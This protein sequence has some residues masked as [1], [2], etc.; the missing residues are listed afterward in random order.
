MT[1]TRTPTPGSDA[2]GERV[3]GKSASDDDPD[4][5]A[6][7]EPETHARRDSYWA[8]LS[9]E[10]ALP[11]QAA[12][13]ETGAW[14]EGLHDRGGHGADEH[15]AVGSGG[16]SAGED[17]AA[18]GG[19]GVGVVS[20]AGE[21]L[22][23]QLRH[24]REVL[25]GVP[26]RLPMV[27]SP[28]LARL[29]AEAT[30][31][32]AVAESARAAL[33]LDAHARGVIASSDNPR[34]DR[35]IEQACRDAGVP[36]T[37]K[38]AFTLKDIAETCEGHDA[39]ALREAVTTGRIGLDSAAMTARFYRRIRAKVTLNNWEPVLADLI[40]AV[41][42]GAT[43]KD[44][45]NAADTIIDQYGEEGAL[46]EG[47]EAA[48]LKRNVSAF[49][50]GRDGMLT[51]TVR[52][53]P[54]SEAIL[55]A[56]LTA[57]SIPLPGPDGERDQRSV[58]QRRADAL[59]ALA[60]K[61]TDA[62]PT[63]PG[64]GSKARVLITIGADTL[65]SGLH[66]AGIDPTTGHHYTCTRTRQAG[67]STGTSGAAFGTHAATAHVAPHGTAATGSAASSATGSAASSATGSAATGPAASRHAAASGSA[68]AGP[69]ASRDAGAARAAASGSAAA[70]PAASGDAGAAGTTAPGTA[71]PGTAAPG[72][73]AG[74]AAPGSAPGSAG[75]TSADPRARVTCTCGA[76]RRGVGITE[77]G[78]ILT[79][80]E[81]RRLAC[82]AGLIPLVLGSKGEVLDVGREQ[83]S[84]T[85]AQRA[86]LIKRDGGCTFPNCTAPPSWCE[87]HH[88]IEWIRGGATDLWN[89]ALLCRH[90]HRETHSKGHL[91]TATIHGVTWTR[92]DGTPIGNTPRPQRCQ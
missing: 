15:A 58:G 3:W 9:D 20:V 25:A 1:T 70:G 77:H 73:A 48:Y 55:T 14:G 21:E 8:G 5:W 38:H 79:P 18:A 88:L 45:D 60:A 41:A 90:H 47:H 30:A 74:S 80:S 65:Y 87:A 22:L 50:T 61:A 44:L 76:A 29:S 36:V 28:D 52:L 91:G 89:L 67:T 46:D 27:S 23:A 7:S 66:H 6:I 54:A 42:N 19:S 59:V 40:E 32:V 2:A 49:R 12:R 39:A 4:F 82:D 37:K 33:V 63:V 62:D 26:A 16:H 85:D 81:V 17:G 64:S 34:V 92:A 53:D 84:A 71:A 68:A 24:I 57:L 78:Q 72:T 56:A 83:R 35:F 31:V 69:A 13:A 10:P 86:A 75:S 11:G 51:A 43:A